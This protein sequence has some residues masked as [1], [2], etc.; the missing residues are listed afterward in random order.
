MMKFVKDLQKKSRS[1]RLLVLWLVSFLVMVFIVI[2]WLTSFSRNFEAKKIE[3]E[4][5]TT[6]F[7]SLFESIEKD[8]STF[9][10]G[11]KAN[12]KFIEENAE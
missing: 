7:P 11:L 9:K 3:K 5:I 4:S 12:V 1:T 8:F 10:E 2:V 6:G